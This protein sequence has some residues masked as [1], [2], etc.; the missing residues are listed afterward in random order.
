MICSASELGCAAV[1]CIAGPEANRSVP[2]VT[3]IDMSDRGANLSAGVTDAAARTVSGSIVAATPKAE[4]PRKS[5]REV[6]D[7]REGVV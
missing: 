2:D 6:P 1:H 7:A 3:Q 4:I 5:R